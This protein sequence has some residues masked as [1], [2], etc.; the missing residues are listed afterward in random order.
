MDEM[1]LIGWGVSIVITLGAFVAVIM[2]FIQPIN[3][4]RVVIQKLLDSIETIKD[5]YANHE[6]RITQHGKEIDKLTI[7]VDK[8][9]TKMEMYHSD[10]NNK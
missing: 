7:R 2:K 1:Q 3:D 6:K 4:L 5:G 10:K 9:E 8:V